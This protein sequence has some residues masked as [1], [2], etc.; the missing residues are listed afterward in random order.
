MTRAWLLCIVALLAL[1]INGAGQSCNFI[2]FSKGNNILP[3]RLCSPVTVNWE[4]HYVGIE[5]LNADVEIHYNWDDGSSETVSTIKGPDSTFTAIVSHTYFSD[6]EK[7]NYHP[8]A[9]LVINDVACTSSSQEQI[10][11]IWDTDNEN[12]G[13]V[14][15]EPEVYPI[16]VGN[17]ATLQ[18]DDGTLFNCVPP[19]ESDVPNECTRWVQWV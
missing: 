10:V 7:C 11:T 1:P 14:N 16:C 9:T 12:G 8:V 4:V 18:F 2:L 19:Q 3:D 15:A 13:E 6:D 5:P 17:G